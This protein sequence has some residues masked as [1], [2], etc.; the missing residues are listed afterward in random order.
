VHTPSVR[1]TFN[2]KRGL[3][4]ALVCSCVATAVFHTIR[5]WPSK[6]RIAEPVVRMSDASSGVA[7]VRVND[8]SKKDEAVKELSEVAKQKGWVVKE[9]APG[10]FATV[11]GD[12]MPQALGA[13]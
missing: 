8:P 12:V 11:P 5:K 10:V 13:K 1:P 9:V 7:V 2:A 6:V 3:A 4:I